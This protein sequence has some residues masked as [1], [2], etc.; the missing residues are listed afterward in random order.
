MIIV[1]YAGLWLAAGLRIATFSSDAIPIP[2]DTQ[3]IVYTEMPGQA[4][5]V[6]EIQGS[7]YR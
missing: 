2:S 6:G 3:V 5:Q 7:H 4:P 1:G